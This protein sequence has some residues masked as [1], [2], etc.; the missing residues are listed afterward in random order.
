MFS[1]PQIVLCLFQRKADFRPAL[2]NSSYFEGRILKTFLKPL[3]LEQSDYS[4]IRDV[5]LETTK[6]GLDI[7]TR[8]NAS[9]KMYPS[10]VTSLPDETGIRFFHA[11]FL[12]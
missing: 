4:E 8:Q 11:Y 3:V 9:I 5:M 7:K 2:I 6:R 10:Y 12:V 1:L